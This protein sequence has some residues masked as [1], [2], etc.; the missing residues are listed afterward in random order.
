MDEW[1]E[2]R[3][4]TTTNAHTVLK[5]LMS[6]NILSIWYCMYIKVCTLSQKVMVQ[7]KSQQT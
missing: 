6:V 3:H 2:R 1:F 4:W 5:D 7:K